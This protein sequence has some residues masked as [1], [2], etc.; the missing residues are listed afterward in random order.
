MVHQYYRFI[1]VSSQPLELIR[2]R[3]LPEVLFLNQS[4][5]QHM[6][7]YILLL[8]AT[9]LATSGLS[10]V[11]I[12]VYHSAIRNM[13]IATRQHAIFNQQ[14]PYVSSN[15]WKGYKE[16]ILSQQLPYVSSK[17]WKGYKEP[18]LSPRHRVSGNNHLAHHDGT[19]LNSLKCKHLYKA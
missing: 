6:S 16:P 13:H 4:P 1:M 2:T 3:A 7:T 18:I 8:F 15:F 19:Y 12:K 5:F 9:H 14:L 17:F 10:H 11:T